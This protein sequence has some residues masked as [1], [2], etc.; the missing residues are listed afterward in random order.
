VVGT[1][2]PWEGNGSFSKRSTL[3][4][5]GNFCCAE[6][7]VEKFVSDNS[8]CIRMSKCGSHRGLNFQ[9]ICDTVWMFLK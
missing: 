9:F 8:K 1:V 4:Q 2:M 3:L 5:G 7:S 6:T